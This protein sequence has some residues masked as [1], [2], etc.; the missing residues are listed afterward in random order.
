MGGPE[1]ASRVRP[2]RRV[3]RG[4][5]RQT[6]AALAVRHAF[7]E[8]ARSARDRAALSHGFLNRAALRRRLSPRGA[9]VGRSLPQRVSGYVQLQP[10]DA[11]CRAAPLGNPDKPETCLRAGAERGGTTAA[12][13][14][15]GFV[16]P[17]PWLA[18]RD[19]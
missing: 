1:R 6:G 19:F 11:L 7:F 10:L 14:W 3:K 4:R 9:D 12:A 15:Y 18:F 8:S 13:F 16:F 5:A 2:L 17:S